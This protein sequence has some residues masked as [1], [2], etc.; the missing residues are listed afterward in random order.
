TRNLFHGEGEEKFGSYIDLKQGQ[1]DLLNDYMHE[2][3]LSSEKFYKEIGMNEQD[4]MDLDPIKRSGVIKNYIAENEGFELAGMVSTSKPPEVAEEEVVGESS[5][6]VVDVPVSF[7]TPPEKPID[8][9]STSPSVS[10]EITGSE[11]AK[12][13]EELGIGEDDIAAFYG[14]QIKDWGKLDP[15]AQITVLEEI[16]AGKKSQ[17]DISNIIQNL[18][19]ESYSDAV[20]KSEA[21]LP[22]NE[23][24]IE[25]VDEIPSDI[26]FKDNRLDNAWKLKTYNRLVEIGVDPGKFSGLTRT[27]QEQ[28]VDI[29]VI[30]GG[31]VQGSP[32]KEVFNHSVE[33]FGSLGLTKDELAQKVPKR[34]WARLNCPNV[35]DEV[36]MMIIDLYKQDGGAEQ[37]VNTGTVSGDSSGGSVQP[38]TNI[39]SLTTEQLARIN[40]QN[41]GVENYYQIEDGSWV[42]E[43]SD[44]SKQ[45]EVL[46]D[47]VFLDRYGDIIVK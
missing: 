15:S 2:K 36:K 6:T 16:S 19:G 1:F 45:T 20:E 42:V 29:V 9:V 21:S 40:M 46:P 22:S 4:F 33:V 32:S 11:V 30:D 44:T 34:I 47:D 35:S 28:F 43:Y 27:Q 24:M 3:G 14:D 37:T 5:T 41:Q 17:E 7:D 31:F 23:D 10:P 39:N 18:P 13:A 25:S 26:V 38:D 8:A 12:K